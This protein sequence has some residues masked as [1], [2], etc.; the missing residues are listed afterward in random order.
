MNIENLD[1]VQGNEIKILGLILSCENFKVDL[2]LKG[3]F[4]KNDI[5]ILYFNIY[6]LNVQNHSAPYKSV[7]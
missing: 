5:L 1:L 3:L 6:H 7:D 2:M 4:N